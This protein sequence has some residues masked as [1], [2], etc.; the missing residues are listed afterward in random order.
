MNKAWRRMGL[1]AGWLAIAA[2]IGLGLFAGSA[3][4]DEKL[5]GIACRS[6]HLGYPAPEGVGFYNEMTVRKSAPGTYFMA[7]GFNMGYFGIQ[8]LGNGKKVVIFSVWDPGNQNDPKIVD[9][10]KR[11]RLLHKDDAVRVGRFGGEG[12]GGQ[13]FLDYDWKMDATYR[14]LVTAEIQGQRTAYSGYFFMPE[15]NEWK[16]LVTFSTPN[17][18]KLLKGY[19]S[20]VEDFRRNMI[21][22]THTRQADFSNGWVRTKEGHWMTLTKARFTADANP[23]LNIDAGITE[24][25]FFLATGGEITNKGTPLW[26]TM[27]RPQPGFPALPGGAF[28]PKPKGGGDQDVKPVKKEGA[29]KKEATEKK[30]GPAAPAKGGGDSKSGGK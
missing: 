27:E 20:F 29:E 30:D 17:G 12:T 1:G 23:V 28:D 16:H 2:A 11:V 21:S 26:K 24:G 25:R 4:A 13:S 18:G 3:G 19:Y 8:E 9:E 6:V 15:K 10:E 5:K 7:C 22:T 14:F